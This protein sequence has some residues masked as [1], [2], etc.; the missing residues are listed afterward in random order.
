[1]VPKCR[2]SAIWLIQQAGAL[3]PGRLPIST[4]ALANAIGRLDTA[5]LLA[6]NLPGMS[7]G[8]DFLNLHSSL[9]PGVLRL[10][11]PA[12]DLV[13]CRLLADRACTPPSAPL[14]HA[15]AP[16]LTPYLRR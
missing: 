9:S 2:R 8:F 1:M 14:G 3:S 15:L 10:D 11:T 7:P 16:S 12:G 6:I 4:P 5:N 13:S